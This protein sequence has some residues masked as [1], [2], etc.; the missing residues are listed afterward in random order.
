MHIIHPHK[1]MYCTCVLCV[2]NTHAIH[3][4]TCIIHILT[5]T[6]GRMSGSAFVDV[7]LSDFNPI[8]THQGPPRTGKLR[9]I[10]VERWKEGWDEEA[11]GQE[12][13]RELSFSHSELPRIPPSANKHMQ[14]VPEASKKETYVEM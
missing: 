9:G 11:R 10:V 8:H 14:E 13:S 6:V 2:D 7:S 12:A 1:C 4:G 3:P 5:H